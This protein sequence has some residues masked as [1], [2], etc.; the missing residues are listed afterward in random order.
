MLDKTKLNT[1]K[2]LGFVDINKHAI[3]KFS[4]VY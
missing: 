1:T 2:M 4:L 3:S